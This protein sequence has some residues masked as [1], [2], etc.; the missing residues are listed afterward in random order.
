MHVKKREREGQEKERREKMYIVL[1][2]VCMNAWE[3]KR[4]RGRGKF[5]FDAPKE[6]AKTFSRGC[7]SSCD[8]MLLRERKNEKENKENF[9]KKN[10]FIPCCS[11]ITFF[12]FIYFQLEFFWIFLYR[13]IFLFFLLFCIS[14]IYK[15]F[16][17]LERERI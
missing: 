17:F 3:R 5:A 10:H 13:I 1:R 9:E 4:N 2:V 11:S 16:F 15:F 8:I 12:F 7:K 14:N 6:S